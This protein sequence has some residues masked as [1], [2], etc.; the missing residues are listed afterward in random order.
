MIS[1]RAPILTYHTI[2]PQPDFGITWI[3][4]RRFEKHMRYLRQAGFQAISIVDQVQ[5]LGHLRKHEKYVT[6]T[7][8]DAYVSVFDFAWPILKKYGF[9]ATVF[10]ISEYVGGSNAW[11]H[12]ILRR[13]LRHCNRDQ[14]VLLAE[15]GWEIGSHS[16]THRLLT[17]LNGPELWRELHGSKTRL[18]DELRRPVKVISYPFGQCNSIVIKYA[19]EAGY[20]AGCTLGSRGEAQGR[21]ALPRR[22]VYLGEPMALFRAK[23]E[24]SGWSRIDNWKQDL[25]SFFAQGTPLYQ[26]ILKR[27][28]KKYLIN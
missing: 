23:V 20:L 14:L 9:T 10:A 22:G 19:S 2:Q 17:S 6:I 8:D 28:N 3:T 4:P 21:F 18:E 1:N 27:H 16:A 13:R 12:H 11:D 24:P 7:F 15:D 26:R 25:V 5:G